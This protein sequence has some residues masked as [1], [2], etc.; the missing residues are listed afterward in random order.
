[1]TIDVDCPGCGSTVR[2]T[3]HARCPR[4]GV[5]AAGVT[6]TKHAPPRQL[7]TLVMVILMAAGSLLMHHILVRPLIETFFD[8]R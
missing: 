5:V 6:R 7:G 8:A 2:W 4:C 3:E 1:M